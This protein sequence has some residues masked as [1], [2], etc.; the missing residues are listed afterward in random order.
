MN[1]AQVT[2]EKAKILCSSPKPPSPSCHSWSRGTSTSFTG[3][4]MLL[5]YEGGATEDTGQNRGSCGAGLQ[6]QMRSITHPC[7]S[8]LNFPVMLLAGD[9]LNSVQGNTRQ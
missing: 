8:A 7:C 9:W 6:S 5:V 3:G 2:T 4:E 1:T